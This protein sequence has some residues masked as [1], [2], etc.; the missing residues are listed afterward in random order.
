M[1]E[2]QSLKTLLH[3][4]LIGEAH[5]LV[6]DVGTSDICLLRN[7][8]AGGTSTTHNTMICSILQQK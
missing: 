8:R 2:T 5:P 6:G 3:S 1:S 4:W 7:G